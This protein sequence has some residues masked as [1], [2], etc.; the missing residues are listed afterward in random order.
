MVEGRVVGR[1][2]K[3]ICKWFNSAKGYGFLVGDGAEGDIFVHYSSLLM[4]GFKVL[5]EAQPVEYTLVETPRGL[6][7]SDVRKLEE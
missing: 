6:Q 4:E 7:A 2:L 1:N 5:K 3:G